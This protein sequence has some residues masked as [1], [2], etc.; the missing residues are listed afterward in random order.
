MPKA[1]WKTFAE[2][3]PERKYLAFAKEVNSR[4]FGLF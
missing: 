3:N 4:A 1:K 2:I